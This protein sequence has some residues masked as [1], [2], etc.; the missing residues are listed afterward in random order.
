MKRS[1]LSLF[2][3][4]PSAFDV[5][6]CIAPSSRK[7]LKKPLQIDISDSFAD[8]A[9]LLP[10]STTSTNSRKFSF[11]ASPRPHSCCM[12]KTSTTPRC[13]CPERAHKSLESN[14]LFENE[15]MYD[16]FYQEEEAFNITMKK[17]HRKKMEDRVNLSNKHK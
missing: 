14:I 8:K 16:D 15:T 17:C 4:A 10:I 7:K 3:N 5:P 2:D 1:F 6:A 12:M 11:S 13:R 9:V